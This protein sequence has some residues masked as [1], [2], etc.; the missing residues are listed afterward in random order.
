M[1]YFNNHM[2]TNGESNN[3][4]RNYFSN[5]LLKWD[6][7]WTFGGNLAAEMGGHFTNENI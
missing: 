6:T 1:A 4:I 3:N 7:K 2:N 5:I